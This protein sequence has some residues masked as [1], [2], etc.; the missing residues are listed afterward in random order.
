MDGMPVHLSDVQKHDYR[1]KRCFA[2]SGVNGPVFY[3][4]TD[5]RAAG[6]L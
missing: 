5:D 1:D 3:S 2:S 4:W 6:Q